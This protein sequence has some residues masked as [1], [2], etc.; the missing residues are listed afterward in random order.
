ML[1]LSGAYL[2]VGG[3]WVE[4][5]MH[6]QAPTL[7]ALRSRTPFSMGENTCTT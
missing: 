7:L 4:A 6:W 2:C 3:S 1:R 5:R